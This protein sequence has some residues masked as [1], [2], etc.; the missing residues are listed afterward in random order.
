MRNSDL[1]EHLQSYISPRITVT[2]INC[3]GLLQPLSW[4]SGQGDGT[5]PV[6]P[7]DPGDDTKGAKDDK[8]GSIW[9]SSSDDSMDEY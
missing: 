2:G 4:D 1:I 6:I 9:D 3:E 8:W 7:G 5:L